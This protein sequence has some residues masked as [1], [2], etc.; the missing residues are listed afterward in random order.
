MAVSVCREFGPFMT[1][2]ILA[3][4]VGSSMA[5]ELGSAPSPEE[6]KRVLAAEFQRLLP[7]F[8]ANR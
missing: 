1:G 7:E 5:A 8:F 4:N 3:A 6:V 2:L